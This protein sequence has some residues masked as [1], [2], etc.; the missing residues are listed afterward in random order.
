METVAEPAATPDA[1][2]AKRPGV[3]SRALALVG[4]LMII[5]GAVLGLYVVWQLFYTDVEANAVQEQ[6]VADLDWAYTP[7]ITANQPVGR[8][9]KGHPG[10]AEAQP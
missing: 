2:R 8:R 6:T 1:T 3:G 5:A 10:R 7:A 9:A 4:E